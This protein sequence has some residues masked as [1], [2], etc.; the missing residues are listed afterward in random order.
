MATWLVRLPGTAAT[1]TGTP[2][3]LHLQARSLRATHLGREAAAA[4]VLQAWESEVTLVCT[5]L[6]VLVRLAVHQ[7]DTVH[8]HQQLTGTAG[9]QGTGRLQ[10]QAE[11]T[12]HPRLQPPQ[13]PRLLQLRLRRRCLRASR[14]TCCRPSE[15]RWRC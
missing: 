6:Q 4:W 2:A 8:Q 7:V 12:G 15:A 14:S 5:A 1:G 11:V 10:G 3:L 9:I 13:R